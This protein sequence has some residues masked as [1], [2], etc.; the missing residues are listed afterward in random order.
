MVKNKS[1]NKSPIFLRLFAYMSIYDFLGFVINRKLINKLEEN[2]FNK[3][4]FRTDF[5]NYNDPS[6]KWV[7]NTYRRVI[8][9]GINTRIRLN[10]KAEADSTST[11]QSKEKLGFILEKYNHYTGFSL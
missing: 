10:R 1:K 9:T 4:K 5:K 3:F 7:V 8:K 11:S 2:L 6:G